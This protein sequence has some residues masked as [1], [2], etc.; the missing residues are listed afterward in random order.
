MG[1][2]VKIQSAGADMRGAIHPATI[3]VEVS[4]G[5][6]IHIVGLTDRAARESLLRVVTALQSLGY[7]I[8][9]KKI[10]VTISPIEAYRRGSNYDLAIAVGILVAT[11]QIPMTDRL[12]DIL[13]NCMFC[14]ELALDGT[15]REGELH[16]GYAM[17]VSAFAMLGG[18]TKSL[19]TGEN[20]AM[21]AAT[22]AGVLVYAFP[23]LA[24]L[25]AVLKQEKGGDQFLVWN[26][27][28]W[29]LVL[30]HAD[31]MKL[32]EDRVL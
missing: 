3:E 4:E 12:E 6:G 30:T 29:T 8:P 26:S 20:S 19:V 7:S 10:I 27:R 2:A 9:G 14:G 31:A 28:Y 32:N 13:Y 15:I 24:D 21:E 5:V 16:Q 17:A 23:S 22:A 25:I 11:G 18:K 1:Q